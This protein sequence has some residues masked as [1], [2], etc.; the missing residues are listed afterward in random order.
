MTSRAG[1]PSARGPGA[2]VALLTVGSR[3]QAT[4][5]SAAV[6]KLGYDVDWEHVHED[7]TDWVG[8]DGESIF[9][10]LT[11]ALT[12]LS[13][14]PDAVVAFGRAGVPGGIVT[15]AGAVERLS[16]EGLIGP[17]TRVVG[18]SARAAR[19]WCDKALIARSL[20]RLGEPIPETVE[21]DAAS[22]PALAARMDAGDFPAGLVVKVVDL[23]GGLGMC[24]AG[25]GRDLARVVDRIGKLGRPMVASEFVDGDEVSVDLLRLGT[26]VLV[27]PP[28][29]K[30]ATDTGL[31]HADHKIKVNGVVR[32]VPE[33]ER[34]VLR[35]AEAFDLQG[36]FSLEAVVTGTR[37]PAWRILE[38]ATRLTNNIQ[39]Q[40]AS[41]GIDS[42]ALL[43]RYVVDEP[44]LPVDER[45]GLGLS[46]PLYVHRGQSSVDALA[47]YPWVRQI[48]L[49]DL[50]EMPASRDDRVRL[51]VKMAVEDL[52]AQLAVIADATGDA[53]VGERVRREIT[54][55]GE[56]YGR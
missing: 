15:I 2:P 4:E 34:S 50:G 22:V 16:T 1:P 13:G 26:D 28:G 48:K 10:D 21:V 49:E 54:R 18:P 23:T 42:V 39:M 14:P 41:L 25:D 8:R 9:R 7:V 3:R 17:G 44:W 36:F 20:R 27:Y 12:R 51:T 29:F 53:A 38:G 45:P 35:I 37:P 6:A 5:L 40:D 33:F 52:D 31:T 43:A 56:T 19:V 55:V 32:T 46:V 11:A 47:A 24:Y 30:R